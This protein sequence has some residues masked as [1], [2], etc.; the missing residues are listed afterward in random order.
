MY[1]EEEDEID[2]LLASML[3]EGAAP[4]QQPRQSSLEPALQRMASY[5]PNQRDA[6]L[7][8][9]WRD[10]EER[11]LASLEGGNEYGLG[12]LL[13]DVLPG[14]VGLIGDAATNGG[15]GIGAIGQQMAGQA[16]QHAARDTQRQ[17]A[18]RDYA[19]KQR[20][21][22]E[23]MGSTA[24]DRD[25]KLANMLAENERLG[26]AQGNY[27]L[28]GETVRQGGERL[29]IAKD[30]HSYDYNPGDQRAMDVVDEL[31]AGG[32]NASARGLPTAALRDRKPV[33]D[34]EV[35]HAFAGIEADD[36]AKKT[37]K[38]TEARIEAE[39]GLA[40]KTAAADADKAAKVAAAS[41]DARV[42]TEAKLAPISA[43]T[44]ATE[45]AAATGARLGAEADATEEGFLGPLARAEVDPERVRLIARDEKLAKEARDKL[46]ASSGIVSVLNDMLDIR[47]KEAQGLAKP[48][49]ARSFFDANRVQLEGLIAGTNMMGV[50]NEGDRAAVGS[51][52]G[53]S[54][55]SPTDLSALL[56]GDIKLEQL[57]GVLDAFMNADRRNAQN[58]GFGEFGSAPA[59]TTRRHVD[60]PAGGSSAPSSAAP[61][62]VTIRLGGETRQVPAEQAKRLKTINP[63]L[64]VF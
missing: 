58:Y 59:K 31:I 52:L 42:N 29:N 54:A 53:K 55:W 27:G 3:S 4:Q 19:L 35:D 40:P 6:A 10:E 16:Q 23:N 25:Y 12:E 61:G 51:F 41:T 13:R 24:F 11:T 62:M 7:G 5:Q 34:R 64:E 2:R 37:A 45:T 26:L 9:R 46:G 47:K 56:G 30:K 14:A 48:G 20:S 39:L 57:S 32:M 18:N 44:K 8:E 38:A 17:E 15:R 22:R 21:Q 50:L 28:R 43:Q 49:A 33:T 63:S 36:N 60:R 1:S